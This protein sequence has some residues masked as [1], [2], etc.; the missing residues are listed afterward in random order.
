MA[1]LLVVDDEANMRRVLASILAVDGHEVV[2]AD[3]VR[4]AQ[5]AFAG[6]PFDLVLTDQ[7]MGDGDGLALLASCHEVD[8]TV[9]VVVMTAF[10]SVE[11]AVEAMKLGAFDFVPKP[12]VP[13]AVRAVVRRAC[14]RTELVR[15]NERLRGQVRRLAQPAGLLGGSRAIQA[16]REL[17]DRVAPTN[18]TVLIHGETGTGKELVARAIHD[19]SPRALRPFVA[20]NCAGF[21]ETLLESELFGHERGAFTGADRTRQ[22][23]FEA[24]HR[25]SLFLDEAGEMPLPLQ[26]KLLRVLMNGEVVRVGVTAAR[27]VD[28]R[29]IVATNRD[30]LAMV[31]AGTFREDLYYRLAVVPIR[32]PALR[33]RREDIPVL[34]DHFLALAGR[35]LKAPARELSGEA[36]ARLVAYDYPGNVRELRNLVERASILARGPVIEA[37]DL[38][39]GGGAPGAPVDGPEAFLQALPETVDLAETMTLV[40]SR[41]VSRALASAHGVQAEAARRLGISRSLLAYKLKALGLPANGAAS[42]RAVKK[43]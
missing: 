43:T 2:E 3:G 10:A 20:V 32:V 24:A 9:P 34:A 38:P 1:R 14:E 12:F 21:A 5:R 18:A 17:I 36:R 41:L 15:E 6:S 39:L 31:R 11:L 29:I 26:A 23:V 8:A 13:E 35:E 7:R 16:I 25:G 30:L 33:E 27:L 19:S 4:A 22:G 42:D 40:E 37:G 28:V